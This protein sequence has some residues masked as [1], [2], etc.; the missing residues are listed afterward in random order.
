MVTERTAEHTMLHK[1]IRGLREFKMFLESLNKRWKQLE[2]AVNKYN[3]ETVRLEGLQLSRIR[4][5]YAFKSST[6][7][8]YAY[9]WQDAL[10]SLEI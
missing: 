10:P 1:H 3:D 6:S 5:I 9:H 8:I 4:N 2:D 7:N